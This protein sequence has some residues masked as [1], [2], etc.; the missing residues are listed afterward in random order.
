MWLESGV[1]LNEI[2]TPAFIRAL[3]E[4]TLS[5]GAPYI[6]IEE[7]FGRCRAQIS[8]YIDYVVLLDLPLEVCLSRVITRN[9]NTPHV[10]SRNAISKYL[11]VYDD[12]LSAIYANVVEQV[13]H[14][15]DLTVTE[16]LSLSKTVVL[17]E[18]WLARQR[19]SQS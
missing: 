19:I 18:R 10:D 13:R 3:E 15:C 11:H 16:V 8:K 12:Y 17:V 5:C 2:K 14:T 4:L 7:P 9:I 6:F 1:D